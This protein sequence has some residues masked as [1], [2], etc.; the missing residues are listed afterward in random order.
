[1]IRL[2]AQKDEAG[3]REK[4]RHHPFGCRLLSAIQAYGWDRPFLRVWSDDSAVYA[5]QD[6]SLT[7]CGR[8]ADGQEAAAFARMV[9]A[10]TVTGR[11]EDLAGWTPFSRQ[12]GAILY[13]PEGSSSGNASD[14]KPP[15]S[16]LYHILQA[17]GLSVP[18]FEAFYLDLNHR[19]RHGAADAVLWEEKACAILG[20]L[21]REEAVLT[22]VAVVPGARREG[23]GS[24]CV[25]EL[26]ARHPGVSFWALRGSG[27]NRAF[28]RQ[29]GFIEVGRWKT[30][31]VGPDD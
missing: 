23:L 29:L 7:V 2:L 11:T 28:Y 21:T 26:L 25:T 17:A 13:H 19:L 12:G 20:A 1:M 24:R 8:P 5:L 15:V 6:S 27:E 31:P 3:L 9:G 14:E 30:V 4:T 18:D 10:S 16:H 22:A